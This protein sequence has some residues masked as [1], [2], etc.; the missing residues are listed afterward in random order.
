MWIFAV[1]ATLASTFLPALFPPC[2]LF[3]EVGTVV[4]SGAKRENLLGVSA[5]GILHC[6]YDSI[7]CPYKKIS[8]EIKCPFNL[9]NPYMDPF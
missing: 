2:Y 7:N 5:D 8:L 6:M 4:V 3:T 9:D 1:L